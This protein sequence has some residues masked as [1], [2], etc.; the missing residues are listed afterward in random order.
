MKLDNCIRN[1]PVT[2]EAVGAR[3]HGNLT[4]P[5]SRQIPS[6][7]LARSDSTDYLTLNPIFGNDPPQ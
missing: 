7:L 1:D 5:C 3:Q 2:A 4:T 6:F